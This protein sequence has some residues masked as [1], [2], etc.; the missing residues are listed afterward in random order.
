MGVV[1]VLQHFTDQDHV[2]TG[3]DL[4]V[5][6]A[7]EPGNHAIDNGRTA[8]HALPIQPGEL[9]GA[10]GGKAIRQFALIA[11]QYIHGE[12]FGRREHITTVGGLGDTH[13]QQRWVYGYRSERI[14]G[15][16]T[17]IAIG[18]ERGHDGHPGG[19]IAKSATQIAAIDYGFVIVCHA[20]KLR[21]SG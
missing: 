10:G 7:V 12:T 9:V 17:G 19:E 1:G 20:R 3:I 8:G 21:L 15:K 11:G 2:I 16:S 4:L 5:V 6:G 14:G 13:Q 18:I